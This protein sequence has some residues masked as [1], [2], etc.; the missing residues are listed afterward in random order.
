MGALTF[1]CYTVGFLAFFLLALPAISPANR[2]GEKKLGK[3]FSRYLVDARIDYFT[4]Y[5][6]RM[7]YLSIENPGKPLLLLLHG[8]PGSLTSFLTFCIDPFLL[9]FFHIVAVDRPGYGYSGPGKPVLSVWQQSRMMRALVEHLVPG[10][11]PGI[12]VA[13]SYSAAIACFMAADMPGLTA[14]MILI[15]ANPNRGKQKRW[16]WSRLLDQPV[17]NWIRPRALVAA[18]RERMK[19]ADER[20]DMAGLCRHINIPVMYLRAE[21]E[22]RSRVSNVAMENEYLA[23]LSSLDTAFFSART[24][25]VLREQQ[26]LI[27]SKIFEMLERVREQTGEWK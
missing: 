17:L 26:S 27:R 25:N 15:S 13:E 4:A 24:R 9:R 21:D 3:F 22:E 7:R 16:A 2:M 6:R 5:G 19:L 14:G 10:K 12:I 23:G 20:H 8:A 11:Q 1:F 18:S